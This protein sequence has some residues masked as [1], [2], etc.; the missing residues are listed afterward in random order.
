MLSPTLDETRKIIADYKAANNTTGKTLYVPLTMELFAD[1]KTPVEVLRAVKKGKKKGI[2]AALLESA[3]SGDNWGRYSYIVF[4]PLIEIIGKNGAVTLRDNGA[5]KPTDVIFGDVHENIK[6]IVGKYVSPKLPTLPDFTGGFVGYF[7]YEY[8]ALTEKT[9]H[10][11]PKDDFGFDDVRLMLF[12]K[13]I[14]FDNFRQKMLLIANI[15]ASDLENNYIKAVTALKDIETLILSD[16]DGAPAASTKPPR[17]LEWS[18]SFTEEKYCAAVEKAKEYIHEGDI[19]QCVPSIR[20]TAPYTRGDLFNAYRCLR[21]T[22]PSAYMFYVD[23]GDLTLSGASPETLVSLKDGTISTF[24][25]AGTCKRG[26]TETETAELI[27]ALLADKKELAEHD[28]LVDLGRNDIGKVSEFGS[29]K[30]TG[31]HS[32]KKLSKVCHIASTVTGKIRADKTA[33][34]ALAA[35]LPAGTLS[36]APKKR[37]AEIINELEKGVKRG[38]Y[39]GG[40]GYIGF[41]GDMD[42]CIGIRMATLR[43][44][45]VF[46]QAGGGVVAD[47]I[48]LNEYNEA[49]A[50]ASA[51]ILAL[52]LAE[53]L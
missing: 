24:P 3:P 23:F 6:N 52:E 49:K 35:V 41:T 28:M 16:I 42:I 25:I 44:E 18:Q 30:V 9:L 1:V 46:V 40:I 22:N 33:M 36:G 51:V 17:K 37:A 32:I 10:I 26:E 39:G 4:N 5:D 27:A 12:D 2:K 19:F 43:N 11:S 15:D 21:T 38:T 53:E 13:L 48:P 31:Y 47:S 20:F 50:K 8:Y 14:A 29:V 34:D 45:K 7:A